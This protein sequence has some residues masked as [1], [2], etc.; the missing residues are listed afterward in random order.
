MQGD[1]SRQRESVR[2]NILHYN[3]EHNARIMQK[4][5]GLVGSNQPQQNDGCTL[6]VDLKGFLWVLGLQKR[7]QA[8]SSWWCNFHELE[9]HYPRT[10]WPKAHKSFQDSHLHTRS[11]FFFYFF[12]NDWVIRL[13]VL[14]QFLYAIQY[15][16]NNTTNNNCVACS[17]QMQEQPAPSGCT[18]ILACMFGNCR[19]YAHEPY[20]KPCVVA[21]RI[22]LFWIKTVTATVPEQSPKN[23]HFLHSFN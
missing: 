15:N 13:P 8:S 1:L 10:L 3:Y 19:S 22:L 9:H 2:V 5:Q 20:A 14:T 7:N 17:A 4:W 18:F 21:W 12:I 16:N 23:L 11:A 6:T